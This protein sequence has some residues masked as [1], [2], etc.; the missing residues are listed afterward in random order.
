MRIGRTVYETH[1]RGFGIDS[2]NKRFEIDETINRRCNSVMKATRLIQTK[3]DNPRIIL[4][5]ITVTSS[6]YSMPIEHFLAECD[7]VTKHEE[8]IVES[9]K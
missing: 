8:K 7:E 9:G 6:Y 1:V 3:Y 5:S 2:E 4:D